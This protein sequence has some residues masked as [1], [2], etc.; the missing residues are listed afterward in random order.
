MTGPYLVAFRKG[1]EDVVLSTGLW[2]M[3]DEGAA[4]VVNLI[5]LLL[6]WVVVVGFYWFFYVVDFL[7]LY[8]TQ[9]HLGVC[10]S[11]I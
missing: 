2:T 8:I 10:W 4:Q 1:L 11:T 6:P 5:V 9:N 3:N 7:M